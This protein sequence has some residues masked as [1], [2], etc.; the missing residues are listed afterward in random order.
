MRL[1]TIGLLVTHPLGLK[2]A[3]QGGPLP[4]H[5]TDSLASCLVLIRQYRPLPNHRRS[6]CRSQNVMPV[7]TNP[8]SAGPWRP[9]ISNCRKGRRCS[10]CHSL[11]PVHHSGPPPWAVPRI[12]TSSFPPAHPPGP[13]NAPNS[14]SAKK[15]TGEPVHHPSEAQKSLSAVA[16]SR[17]TPTTV[18]DRLSSA[19][20]GIFR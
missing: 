12:D 2:L 6:A 1:Q 15:E 13:F 16:L 19:G 18:R 5:P 17:F 3:Y 20:F 7:P 4:E 14:Y 11:V 8:T 10:A 9:P